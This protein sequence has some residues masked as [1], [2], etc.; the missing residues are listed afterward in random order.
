MTLL[1]FVGMLSLCMP[2]I[3]VYAEEVEYLGLYESSEIF[4]RWDFTTVDEVPD[5]TKSFTAFAISKN[6]EYA[7]AIFYDSEY[8]YI[9]N[10]CEGNKTVYRYNLP[11]RTG[12]TLDIDENNVIYILFT[13][14]N[15]FLKI[16]NDAFDFAI[17]ENVK[18]FELQDFSKEASDNIIET[19]V[20]Y[21]LSKGILFDTLVRYDNDRQEVL[22][23]E[24]T[25]GWLYTAGFI[26]VLAAAIGKAT[27]Y[28]LFRLKTKSKN[29]TMLEE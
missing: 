8:G 6:E 29:I 21:K 24:L 16:E 12:I 18:E 9:V 23:R 15:Y 28:L 1:C 22:Y 4:E 7:C 19:D 27:I 11:D 5:K 26:I 2:K 3:N 20:E 13:S 25:T 17:I 14:G 10:F